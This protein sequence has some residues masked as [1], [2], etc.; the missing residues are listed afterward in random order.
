MLDV[1]PFSAGS[2][3]L[4]ASAITVL[5]GCGAV[6]LA[7]AG[8][9]SDVVVR[10]GIAAAV[11]SAGRAGLALPAA[12]ARSG[13]AARVVAALGSAAAAFGAAALAMSAGV[14]TLLLS[15]VTPFAS[16]AGGM[17]RD[18]AGEAVCAGTIAGGDTGALTSLPLV[19]GVLAFA[20][21]P[22]VSPSLVGG[23]AAKA[24]LGGEVAAALALCGGAGLAAPPAPPLS[25]AGAVA[26]DFVAGAVPA[27]VGLVMTGVLAGA[28]V[29]AVLGGAAA[30]GGV[31]YAPLLPCGA[32]SRRCGM[33]VHP[34]SA[35]T[36][37]R[38]GRGFADGRSGL[39][40][41]MAAA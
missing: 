31:P 14:A 22:P 19:T 23:T 25:L 8:L 11:P 24:W 7:A 32:V 41:G 38:Q 39:S 17:G 13:V 9:G 3:G 12:A 33:A 36:A 28:G 21:G 37:S 4:A 26:G 15:A 29:A 27:E 16:G 34:P 1:L 10:S 18:G 30:T 40:L 5:A 20:A 35:T 6:V 2:A